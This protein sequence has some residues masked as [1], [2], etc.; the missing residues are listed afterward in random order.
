MSNCPKCGGNAGASQPRFS[1]RTTRKPINGETANVM[2][3]YRVTFDLNGK[4]L[5]FQT[6]EV[7][8]LDY[9]T[10]G[11]ALAL[12]PH[13]LLFLNPAEKADYEAKHAA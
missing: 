10:I 5:T 8:R 1:V 3:R 9:V 12:S 11:A 2:F 4:T 6:S 7:I 13:C